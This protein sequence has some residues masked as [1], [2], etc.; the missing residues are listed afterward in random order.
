MELWGRWVDCPAH[1][2]L[3]AFGSLARHEQDSCWDALALE[4]DE[5]NEYERR[6]LYLEPPKRHQPRQ[7]STAATSARPRAVSLSSDDPLKN[8]EPRLYVEALT[9]E[10][11]PASGWLSCP[12]PDHED[13]TPSFQVLASHWRCFGCGRGGSVIDFAAAW[14]GIAPRG[15]GYWELRDLIVE[16]LGGATLYPREDR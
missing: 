7:R 6:E 14:Y 15:R 13:R 1:C 8:I 10:V 3:V 2:R 9:G 16:A 12:L 5:R 11:V 4:C